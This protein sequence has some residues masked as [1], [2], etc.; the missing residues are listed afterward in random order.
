LDGSHVYEPYFVFS[1]D[2]TA[3]DGVNI[4]RVIG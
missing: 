1:D 3:S 2:A 4:N